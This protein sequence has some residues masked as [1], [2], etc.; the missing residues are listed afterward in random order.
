MNK[1]Y[2]ITEIDNKRIKNETIT[3]LENYLIQYIDIFL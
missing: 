2:K 3:I 1:R